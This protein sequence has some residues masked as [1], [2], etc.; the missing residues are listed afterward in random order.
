MRGWTVRDSLEL[1]SVTA[2]GAGFFT[3]NDKGHVE[4]RPHGDQGPGIDLLDL[5]QDLDQRGL[6]TPLLVRL[7][8][9]LASRV[10]GLCGAFSRAINDYGYK[11]GFRGV[12]P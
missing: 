7:S 10:R 6:R 4:V 5:V 11:G 1:Y 9:I 3:V 2:W 12:Y 8:D